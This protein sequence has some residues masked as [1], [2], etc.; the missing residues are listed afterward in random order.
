MFAHGL[1]RHYALLQNHIMP[2]FT[3]QVESGLSTR[4]Q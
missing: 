3:V 4:R 2:V 1:I